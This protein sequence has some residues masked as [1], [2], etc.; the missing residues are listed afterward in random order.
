MFGHIDTSRKDFHSGLWKNFLTVSHNNCHSGSLLKSGNEFQSVLL[1]RFF[2]GSLSVSGVLT[3][4]LGWIDNQGYRT[5][6][7]KILAQNP[8]KTSTHR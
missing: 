4:G 1:L 5:N 6:F 3:L 7:T 8:E 2:A